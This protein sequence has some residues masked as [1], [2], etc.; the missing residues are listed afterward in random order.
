MINGMTKGEEGDRTG[1]WLGNGNDKKWNDINKN[2]VN[3]CKNQN[4]IIAEP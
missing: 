4:N 1:Q 2:I 3:S